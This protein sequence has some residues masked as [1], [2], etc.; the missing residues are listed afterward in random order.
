MNNFKVLEK[1]GEGAFA[2][3]YKVQRISDGRIYALKKMKLTAV[4]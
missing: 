2:V 4:S 1:V 3:V